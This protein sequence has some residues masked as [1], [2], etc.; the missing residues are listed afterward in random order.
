MIGKGC[1]KAY[2]KERVN[3]EAATA[4]PE[5][6]MGTLAEETLD[7]TINGKWGV[8]T[9]RRRD[10]RCLLGLC[11]GPWRAFRHKGS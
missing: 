10:P 5:K 8:G 6:A 2:R 7:W 1:L 3:R 9:L 11:E 4:G